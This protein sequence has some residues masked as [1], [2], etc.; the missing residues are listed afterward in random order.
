MAC[1]LPCVGVGLRGQPIARHRRR[2]GLLFDPHRPEELAGACGGCS[3][4]PRSPRGSER[5]D[6]P[7]VAERYDLSALVA[8]EIAL[9]RSVARR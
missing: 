7:L 4:I 1:G 8:R 9:V 3:T 5:P 2:D 6:A